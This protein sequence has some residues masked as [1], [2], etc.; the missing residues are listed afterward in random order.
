[1]SRLGR[2]G[3]VVTDNFQVGL[4]AFCYGVI[5]TLLCCGCTTDDPPEPEPNPLVVITEFVAPAFAEDVPDQGAAGALVERDG[6]VQGL[7]DIGPM[8]QKAKPILDWAAKT[9]QAAER[10]GEIVVK[11]QIPKTHAAPAGE[12]TVS[13]A[14]RPAVEVPVEA[15][16]QD[17]PSCAGGSC[18]TTKRG[19]LWRIRRR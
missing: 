15:D 1:M 18:S 6:I 10:D 14:P 8:I 4:I 16:V 3:R 13:P 5:M 12:A 17:G 9:Q 19:L 7:R 11:V 2:G